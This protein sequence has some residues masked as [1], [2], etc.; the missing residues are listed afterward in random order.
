MIWYCRY[1]RGHQPN[2]SR[3]ECLGTGE[4]GGEKRRKEEERRGGE[5]RR[6]EEER[7]EGE[8]RKRRDGEERRGERRRVEN[9]RTRKRSREEE[10]KRREVE[11][12]TILSCFY[13]CNRKFEL[14]KKTLEYSTL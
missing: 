14:K 9:E 11:K 5:K 13:H 12:H 10:K 8:E 2:V 6:K 1:Y 4:R 3:G 7:R